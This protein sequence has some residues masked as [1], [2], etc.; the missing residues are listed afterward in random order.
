M[1]SDPVKALAEG[2]IT[3]WRRE[4]KRMKAY[5]RHLAKWRV[6]T[7]FVSLGAVKGSDLL[8]SLRFT[9]ILDRGDS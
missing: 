1:I 2:A 9:V 5:Y 6:C 3:P 7:F 8:D 4:T